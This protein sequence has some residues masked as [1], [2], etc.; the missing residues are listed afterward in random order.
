MVRIRGTGKKYSLSSILAEQYVGL[1]ELE[2]NKWEIQF[3]DLKIGEIDKSKGKFIDR[4]IK[5]DEGIM[6]I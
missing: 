3:L 6:F 5:K 1:T 2:D 4:V